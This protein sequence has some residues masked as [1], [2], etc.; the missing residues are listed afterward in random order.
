M[1]ELDMEIA[2]GE[3]DYEYLQI[4]LEEISRNMNSKKF[5]DKYKKRG[6]SD[7][8]ARETTADV[9]ELEENVRWEDEDDE[10]AS[11]DNN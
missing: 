10:E 2:I 4:Y 3:E 6:M 9:F 8:L 5:E 11:K 1:S 7:R